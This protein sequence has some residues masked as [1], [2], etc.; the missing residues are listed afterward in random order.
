MHLNYLKVTSDIFLIW[1][2]SLKQSTV[3]TRKNIPYFTSKALFV[4]EIFNF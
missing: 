3:E 4:L 2:L 1:V